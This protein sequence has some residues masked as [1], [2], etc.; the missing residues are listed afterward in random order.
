M[1]DASCRMHCHLSTNIYLMRSH[2]TVAQSQNFHM[3]CMP[4]T[5]KNVPLWVAV[6]T[7]VDLICS[8][9]FIQNMV[10]QFSHCMSLIRTGLD[11]NENSE[12]HGYIS[13]QSL[14]L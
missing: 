6:H 11:A 9:F 12:L 14:F 4:V 13:S 2:P 3:G 8:L 10:L 1:W 7:I 5:P